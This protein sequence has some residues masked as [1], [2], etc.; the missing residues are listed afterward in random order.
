MSTTYANI[1]SLKTVDNVP[2][3]NYVKRDNTDRPFLDFQEIKPAPDTL[4][5]DKKECPDGDMSYAIIALRHFLHQMTEEIPILTY[6]MPRLSPIENLQYRWNA[7][8]N[9]SAVN[10]MIE[11]GRVYMY[12]YTTTGHLTWGRWR[13]GNW[14]CV[15]NGLNFVIESDKEI[16]FCTIG[17]YPRHVIQALSALYPDA[18]LTLTSIT[19]ISDDGTHESFGNI[20]EYEGGKLFHAQ[21]LSEPE[22][23]L[24]DRT[25]QMLKR[26]FERFQQETREES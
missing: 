11:D 25:Y 3:A 10:K 8:M 19:F 21:C 18:R 6:E 12:N 16:S 22:K 23:M 5:P 15:S 26:Q 13:S 9:R 14:G 1:V 17:G 4:N 7:Y 2:F 20:V 24:T